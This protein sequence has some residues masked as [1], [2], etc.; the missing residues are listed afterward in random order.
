LTIRILTIS[1][2]SAARRGR[3]PARELLS[4]LLSLADLLRRLLTKDPNARITIDGL[5]EQLWFGQCSY[6]ALIGLDTAVFHCD[7]RSVTDC[8]ARQGIDCAKLEDQL[9]ANR[10]SGLT[11]VYRELRRDEL[12][13]E[14]KALLDGMNSFR[15]PVPRRTMG[16]PNPTP[17]N[18]GG[19]GRKC[20]LRPG[21]VRTVT[22]PVRS[23]TLTPCG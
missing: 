8:M 10:F 4:L 22:G 3:I 6:C 20:P 14:I 23:A 18:G 13:N 16:P 12:T 7:A 19:A 1:M 5:T 17:G 11:A 9:R 15:L 2:K 21:Q